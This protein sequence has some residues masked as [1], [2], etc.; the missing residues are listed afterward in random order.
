MR[1]SPIFNTQL[2]STDSG[3]EFAISSQL[4]AR[5]K[6]HLQF[7]VLRSMNGYAERQ[8]LEGFFLQR[9]GRLDDFLF[10]DAD[11]RTA[12]AQ[13]IGVGNGVNTKFQLVRNLGGAVEPIGAV[14]G[15][16]A[17]LINGSATTAYTVDANALVTFNSAPAVGAVV[18]WSGAFFFRVRFLQDET[19]FE[20]FLQG[21]HRGNVEFRSF[22]P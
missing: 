6:F 16:P 4:Y 7:E 15:T 14:D 5:Y 13:Q 18:S 12:T 1:R 20:R 10:S 17:I 21:L 9:R 19:E 2:S 22:R 3:R 8:A 11:D